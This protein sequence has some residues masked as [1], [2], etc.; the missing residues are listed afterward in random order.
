MC[1]PLSVAWV[2]GCTHSG[3]FAGTSHRSNPWPCPESD[4]LEPLR[5][6]GVG[7]RGENDG[8]KEESDNFCITILNYTLWH[9]GG[10]LRLVLFAGINFSDCRN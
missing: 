6:R 8:E 3:H 10:T 1:Y 2:L 4:S 9:V 7:R 5:K